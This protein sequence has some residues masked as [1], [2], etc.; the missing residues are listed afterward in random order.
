METSKKHSKR[1]TVEKGY[2]HKVSERH[3]HTALTACSFLMWMNLIPAACA[4][5]PTSMTGTP[6]M[7]NM[8]STPCK[9]TDT[10][11]QRQMA[12]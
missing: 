5:I 4:A 10:N 2:H 8:Y 6:T 1:Q 9:Q 12:H 7:P 3:A 11:W